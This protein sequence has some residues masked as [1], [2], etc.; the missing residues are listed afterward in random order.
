[1]AVVSKQRL[2]RLEVKAASMPRGT[3]P[4]EPPDV[5][6]VLTS[7]VDSPF[8]NS[9]DRIK[10]QVDLIKMKMEEIKK[11]DI[12]NDPILEVL[13]IQNNVLEIPPNIWFEHFNAPSGLEP[14]MGVTP[15]P[16]AV[17][18]QL[19]GYKLHPQMM[20]RDNATFYG[21]PLTGYE[22]GTQPIESIHE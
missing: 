5:G 14:N 7:I 6:G 13:N 20:L 11:A 1:M 8:A 4:I 2:A 9:S 18:S 3:T 16:P 17:E 12:Q 15:V 19:A 10:A 22:S 21:Q